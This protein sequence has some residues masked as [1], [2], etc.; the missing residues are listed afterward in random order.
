ME[1][2]E[3]SNVE[4]VE[5]PWSDPTILCEPVAAMF[6]DRALVKVLP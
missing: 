4:L 5:W 1:A 2:L 3:L 6:L